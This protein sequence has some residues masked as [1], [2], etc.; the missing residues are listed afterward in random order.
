VDSI[1][2]P[3][4]DN[5][6]ASLHSSSSTTMRFQLLQTTMGYRTATCMAVSSRLAPSTITSQASPTRGN[7]TRLPQCGICSDWIDDICSSQWI[8]VDRAGSS[9]CD[10]PQHSDFRGSRAAARY[11]DSM[12]RFRAMRGAFLLAGIATSIVGP[13]AML[14]A[15]A[16]DGNDAAGG[17]D[18][19]RLTASDALIW[20]CAALAIFTASFVLATALLSH[21][22][23]ESDQ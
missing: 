10:S 7:W 19:A 21:L 23:R 11:V 9:A 22:N 14:V 18:Q 8:H 16:P 1:A 15:Y 12:F 17:F 3:A 13:L 4:E 2:S 5:R 6:S 20:M